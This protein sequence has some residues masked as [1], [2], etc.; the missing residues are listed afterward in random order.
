MKKGRLIRARRLEDA[1]DLVARLTPAQLAR[2]LDTDLW[3]PRTPGGEE[4]FDAERFGLWIAVLMEAG[5]PVAAEKLAGLDPELVVEGCARHLR[6]FDQAAVSGYVTLEGELVAARTPQGTAACE[7]GGYAI[8]SRL[9]SAWDPLIEL[10]AY[11]HAEQ[12]ALFARFMSGCVRLSSAPREED[13]FHDL[14]ED[15]AQH[16][17]DLASARD[18]RREQEGFVAPAQA[19]A[20]LRAARTLRLD[21]ARPPGDGVAHAYFRAS[22]ITLSGASSSDHAS[23]ALAPRH[24]SFVHAYAASRADAA[25]ELGFLTNALAAGGTVQ[26]RGLTV[27]EAADGAVAIAN[28]GLENWPRQW[29]SPDL[30]TAFQAGWAT[31]HRD[32]CLFTARQLIDVLLDVQ[33]LDRDIQ[34][35]LDGLR[36]A[37]APRLADG[38]P[39]R[40][41]DALEAIM[42]LDVPCWASLNTLIAECPVMHA[43]LSSQG[44]RTIDP[45]AFTFI[46]ENEQI[47]VVRGFVASLPS[48]LA[49]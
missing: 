42:M 7:I 44:A 29:G 49:G 15:D 14:L 3:Q 26:G 32:V 21:T 34:L 35:R 10:L 12:P 39:W 22:G 33:C 30:V 31:L 4:A 28:L 48:V 47:A 5:A 6:V 40:A 38:E 25:S 1:T 45:A 36:R 46:A 8:E 27:R 11:L 24:Q 9:T 37:L 19:Q 16:A 2:V 41:H 18:A 20:F 13:G 23:G 17:F 43:A